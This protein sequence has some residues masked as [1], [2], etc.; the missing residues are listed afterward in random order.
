MIETQH[1]KVTRQQ[2]TTAQT[3]Q[4]FFF[5]F[6]FLFLFFSERL[7]VMKEG[8]VTRRAM[9][10]VPVITLTFQSKPTPCCLNLALCYCYW[11][12]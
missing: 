3:P 2:Q 12:A 1:L 5:G 10:R 4:L 6:F 11:Q 9:N 7:K 8:Q